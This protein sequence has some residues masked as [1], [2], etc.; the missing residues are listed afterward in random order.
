MSQAGSE[1]RPEA[2]LHLGAH[3]GLGRAG[4]HPAVDLDDGVA[5][6]DVVLD[7][8]VDDVRAE[9]VADQ[10]AQGAGVHRVAQAVDG[11][12]GRGAVQLA[13]RDAPQ[14]RGRLPGE[15]LGGCLEEPGHDRRD[16]DRPGRGQALDRTSGQDG[17]V[18]GA[19]HRTVAP[20][21]A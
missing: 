3:L 5:R 18:V 19:R 1:I 13:R 21:A 12:I 20:R 2:A 15:G 10:G 16:P 8:G 9:R 17:G 14:D 6:D 7:A 4:Q 11:G